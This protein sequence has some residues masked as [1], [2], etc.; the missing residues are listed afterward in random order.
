[1]CS[2]FDMHTYFSL[3]LHIYRDHDIVEA[4]GRDGIILKRY[5]FYTLRKVVKVIKDAFG[6]EPTH[7]CR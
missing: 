5:S 7:V 2:N 4:L 3:T 6:V 1:M